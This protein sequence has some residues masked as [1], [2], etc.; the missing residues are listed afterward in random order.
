MTATNGVG[1]GHHATE[2]R[3]GQLDVDVLGVTD[4]DAHQRAGTP[5]ADLCRYEIDLVGGELADRHTT[6]VPQCA[7]EGG[8]RLRGV[9][10]RAMMAGRDGTPGRKNQGSR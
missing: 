4:L 8:E 6:N 7:T 10:S 5:V 9:V 1:V 3:H 2:D